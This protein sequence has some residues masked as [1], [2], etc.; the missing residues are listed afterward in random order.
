MEGSLRVWMDDQAREYIPELC[1]VLSG[2]EAE[3]WMR[4]KLL[5]GNRDSSKAKAAR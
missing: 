5:V 4:L 2:P 1:G 3:F